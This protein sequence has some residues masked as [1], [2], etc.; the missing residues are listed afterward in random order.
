MKLR[1]EDGKRTKKVKTDQ[2]Q[3]VYYSQ[4]YADKQKRERNQMIERANDLIKNPKK[5]NRVTVGG[6]AAY[7]NNIKFVKGTGEIADGLNLSLNKER[8]A[9][10]EKYDGYYSIV[11][12]ELKIDDFE[13][14]KVYRGLAKIEESFKITKSELES[15]PVYVWTKEHIESHFLTCFVSLVI[16]RLLEQKLE[17]KYSINKIIE[18]LKNFG[19]IEEFSNIFM[20]FNNSEIVEKLNEIY[21]SNVTKK[22]LPKSY[23][24]NFLNN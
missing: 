15:R 7:I 21:N 13:L 18:S 5:Y 17:H 20:L 24:K 22:R 23:I 9:E 19:C 14:R 1:S 4:K 11:T 10:E 2:K 16:L 6:S 3:L 8:I 12:S